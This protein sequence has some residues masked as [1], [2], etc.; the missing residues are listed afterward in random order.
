LK[1]PF[2]Q[3]QKYRRISHSSGTRY[4]VRICSAIR[5]LDIRRWSDLSSLEELQKIG[6]L[7]GW[8]IVCTA[9]GADCKLVM[10]PIGVVRPRINGALT[11]SGDPDQE[12]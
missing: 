12:A 6:Y 11:P 2:F 7:P 1:S 8:D 3:Y 10:S 5:Q 4:L 9:D